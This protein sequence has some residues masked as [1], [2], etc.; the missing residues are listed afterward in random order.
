MPA[1]G[2]QVAPSAPITE[3]HRM[4]DD[5]LSKLMT[6]LEHEPDDPFCLYGIAQEHAARGDDEVALG[7]YER[8]AAADP[9]DGYVHYH[10]ARS[11]ERLGRR[12]EAAETIRRGQRAA[13]ASGD[14]HARAE[15]DA[16][17]DELES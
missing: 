15:L 2:P 9:E 12:S 10:H 1:G 4:T 6:L 16:F 3:D 5:R 13:D 11:L 17:L 7:W 8:A 14:A